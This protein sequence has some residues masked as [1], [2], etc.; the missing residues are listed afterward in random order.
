MKED[1]TGSTG[2][3]SVNLEDNCRPM[4]EP[5]RID[6]EE[7]P[8]LEPARKDQ[9]MATISLFFG[10]REIKRRKHFKGEGSGQRPQCQLLRKAKSVEYWV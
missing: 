3:S 5:R 8:E 7:G 1:R 9:E 6:R 4:G 2:H 10:N